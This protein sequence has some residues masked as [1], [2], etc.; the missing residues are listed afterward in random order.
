MRKAEKVLPGSEMGFRGAE[1]PLLFCIL[2][3]FLETVSALSVIP[4]RELP[5]SA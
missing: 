3:K 2:G 4:D 5:A 1:P